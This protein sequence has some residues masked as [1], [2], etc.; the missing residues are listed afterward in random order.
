MNAIIDFLLQLDTTLFY[1]FNVQL[2]NPVFDTVMPVITATGNWRYVAIAVGL[3]WLWKGGNKGRWAVLY[4]VCAWGLSDLFNSN[5]VKSVFER[6][7]PCLTLPDVHLLVGCG[8]TYSF[9]SGHAVTSFAIATFLSL[10]Y[11]RGRWVLF[12]VAILISYSRIA[13]GVHY[14]FDILVGWV[15]GAFFGYLF[16]RFYLV[17]R[18]FWQKRG[19]RGGW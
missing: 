14:P 7:R 15:E 1:F 18:D 17:Q 10:V 2:A 5:L 4:A 8:Q 9:P 16:Y 3:F 12:P 6:P 11:P 19:W 13:V